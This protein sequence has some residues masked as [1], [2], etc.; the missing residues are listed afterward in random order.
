MKRFLAGL[1]VITPLIILFWCGLAPA[2]TITSVSP[3][4]A[5]PG[6]L[7]SITILSGSFLAVPPATC[8]TI[9][10]AFGDGQ[11]TGWTVPGTPV[12]AGLLC[13]GSTNVTHAYTTPGAYTITAANANYPPSPA[14][15]P[16]TISGPTPP[17]ASGLTVSPSPGRVGEPVTVSGTLPAAALLCR[18]QLSYGD[19]ST[20]DELGVCL[21]ADPRNFCTFTRPHTFAQPGTF[22]ITLSGTGARCP[23]PVTTTVAINPRE[24]ITLPPGTVTIPYQYEFPPPGKETPYYY[25][26]FSGSYPPGI[27]LE[28]RGGAPNL[29]GTPTKPGRYRFTLIIQ[30]RGGTRYQQRYLLEIQNPPVRIEA[31]PGS[32]SVPRGVTT[33]HTVQYRFE[34]PAPLNIPLTSSGGVFLVD[35]Q[36]VGTNPRPMTVNLVNGKAQDQETITITPGVIDRA[37]GEAKLPAGVQKIAMAKGSGVVVYERTFVNGTISGVA[38]I[39]YSVAS[40]TGAGFAIERLNIY[41]DNRRPDITIDRNFPKL[42]AHVD[43]GFVGTGQLQGHWEVDG[44]IIGFENRHVTFG[45]SMAG[46]QYLTFDTPEIPPLPT[47]DVGSH[48]VRFVIT[49]PVITVPQPA[50][51]YFVREEEYLAATRIVLLQPGDRSENAAGRLQFA[52]EG[53]RRSNT[54]LVEFFGPRGEKPIFSALTRKPEYVLPEITLGKIFEKGTAYTWKVRSLDDRNRVIGESDLWRFDLK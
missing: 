52:W 46:T 35:G 30:D 49:N 43:I 54:Y 20:P 32:L 10:V 28:G 23:P 34:S 25:F 8:G 40:T 3:N 6:Q 5:N 13:G 2:I 17:P 14:T 11:S 19:G 4:P 29:F 33:T 18:Y 39:I 21:P 51:I 37:A 50:A 15:A 9:S 7:V 27:S 45:T 36:T 47:F 12:G 24:E 38:R 44:R 41:F 53:L 1:G 42:R 31:V 16:V 26:L 48:V 22:T